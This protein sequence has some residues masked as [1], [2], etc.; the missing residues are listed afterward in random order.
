MLQAAQGFVQYTLKTPALLDQLLQ[1]L[2]VHGPCAA[3]PLGHHRLQGFE[4]F[5]PCRR[6]IF[7]GARYP[8]EYATV[9]YTLVFDACGFNGLR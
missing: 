1:V 2:A 3:V 9:M 6:G 8:V 5:E 7:Q 4:G